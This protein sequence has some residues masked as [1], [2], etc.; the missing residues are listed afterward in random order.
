MKEIVITTDQQ[1]RYALSLVGE[2][3]LDGTMQVVVRKVDESST[4][5]QRRLQW[6]WYSEIAASGLGR[7]DSKEGVHLDEKWQCCRPILLRDDEVFGII[8]NAFMDQVKGS[9]IFEQA[10]RV[11]AQQ[12]ISTERLT[13][14][15]RA[16]YLT[17]I[18][19]KWIYRGVSLTD[20]DNCGKDLLKYV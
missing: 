8:Y 9:V 13:K 10:C 11:F 5:K 2:L 19:H 20:P 1:R 6:L 14:K 16:E 4:A 12:Y 3:P 17:E 18:Q 15:Q 7:N